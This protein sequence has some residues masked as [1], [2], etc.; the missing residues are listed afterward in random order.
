M[1]EIVYKKQR[2]QKRGETRSARFIGLLR[3]VRCFVVNRGG[4]IRRASVSNGFGVKSRSF[5]ERDMR[6][7]YNSTEAAPGILGRKENLAQP[8]RASM[9]SSG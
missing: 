7:L 3:C 8:N 5:F 9:L 4:L 1:C 2:E 6:L